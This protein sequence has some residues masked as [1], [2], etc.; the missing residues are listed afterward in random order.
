MSNDERKA[1]FKTLVFGL[2]TIAFQLLV[3]VLL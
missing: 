3:I 2:A 1:Y